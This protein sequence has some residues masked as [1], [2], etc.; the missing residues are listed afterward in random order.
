MATI[1]DIG[2]LAKGEAGRQKIRLLVLQLGIFIGLDFEEQMWGKRPVRRLRLGVIAFGQ[3]NLPVEIHGHSRVNLP[4]PT[5][6][7]HALPALGGDTQDIDSAP[8]CCRG[9]TVFPDSNRGVGTEKHRT[10]EFNS[11]L[12]QTHQGTNVGA[13][14]FERATSTSRT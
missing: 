7:S 3:E 5:P 2:A 6:H 4:G 10:D 9:P 12:E 11:G 1:D 14:R 13:T 8:A